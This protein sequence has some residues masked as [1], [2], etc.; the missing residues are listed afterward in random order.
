M[1]LELTTAEL[2]WLAS[3]YKTTLIPGFSAQR[4]FPF[5]PSG[6]QAQF[7]AGQELLLARRLINAQT[8]AESRGA[9]T[10]STALAQLTDIV[11]GATHTLAI[12]ISTRKDGALTAFYHRCAN[13]PDGVVMHTPGHDGQHAFELFVDAGAWRGGLPG[14]PPTSAPAAPHRFEIDSAIWSDAISGQ[15]G[16]AALVRAIEHS[17]DPPRDAQ[18]V[19]SSAKRLNYVV[20]YT[21][22]SVDRASAEVELTHDTLHMIATQ[23][24]TWI[25]L[26]AAED[27]LT[28]SSVDQDGA[29]AAVEALLQ[30]FG[31]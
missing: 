9:V 22:L 3:Y 17:D 20:I 26:P 27:R 19:L 16:L 12:T 11:F 2:Y 23:T 6:A 31:A 5:D 18:A 24:V 30:R 7:D 29:Q 15:A 1:K 25:A 8:S 21:A 13:G 28:V 14:M 10:V 4:L